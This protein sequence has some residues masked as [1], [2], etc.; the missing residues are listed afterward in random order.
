MSSTE[1]PTPRSRA[2]VAPGREGG[3]GLAHVVAWGL[4][5]PGA[6]WDVLS[7]RN[8]TVEAEEYPF[9]MCSV[10]KRVRAGISTPAVAAR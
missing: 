9:A 1:P 8:C 2:A 4:Q 3:A 6:T 10:G 5:E 7:L